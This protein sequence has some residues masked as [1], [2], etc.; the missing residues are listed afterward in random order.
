MQYK[1]L[2]LRANKMLE[3][4][5]GSRLRAKV[6]GWL[7]SHPDERYFVR[8]MSTI[9][10]KDSTNVSRELARLAK[11]G[12]LVSTAEGK[13]R[14]YQAN[15]HSPVFKELKTL[16]NRSSPATA[17]AEATLSYNASTP[18]TTRI[19]RIAIPR[20]KLASFCRW[21][22]IRKLALFG[23]VL[24]DDFRPDSDIDVLVEFE[25]GKT[26]GYFKIYDMEMELSKLLKGRKVDLRTP[27][28]L[29]RYFR[30]QV[31]DEARVAYVAT[32]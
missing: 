17:V 24:R 12:I 29:S 6:L 8:Q 7:F 5:F 14:Y 21:H 32:G 10:G 25:P 26:P 23:S 20:R 2:Q 3:T 9:V 15:Q 13:Q 30:Q 11:T 22:S 27:G 31:L 18:S 1:I 4:L 19:N 16:I 28:D